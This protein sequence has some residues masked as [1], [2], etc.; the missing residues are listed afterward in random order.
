VSSRTARAIQRNPVSKNKNKKTKQTKN[1]TKRQTPE[2]TRASNCTIVA[3]ERQRPLRCLQEV[4]KAVRFR[5]HLIIA[6][7][8]RT[9]KSQTWISSSF[10]L[11]H[12]P[13]LHWATSPSQLCSIPNLR[14]TLLNVTLSTP[15]ILHILIFSEKPEPHDS[16][17]SHVN[18][19][20]FTLLSRTVSSFSLA[21]VTTSTPQNESLQF[22]ALYSADFGV[23]SLLTSISLP[24]TPISKLY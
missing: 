12:W 22:P 23:F 2:G 1:K 5:N 13:L 17:P 7:W 4:L 19:Y 20:V 6:L 21:S 15:K 18:I 3:A 8:S 11:P 10:L 9:R 14:V 24:L 16:P